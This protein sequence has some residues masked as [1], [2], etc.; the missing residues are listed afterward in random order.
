MKSLLMNQNNTIVNG[1]I[2]WKDNL[3]KVLELI[4]IISRNSK[5]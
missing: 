3:D 2:L 5:I 1:L 4:I